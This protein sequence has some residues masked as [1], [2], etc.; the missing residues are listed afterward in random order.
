MSPQEGPKK[1]PHPVPSLPKVPKMSPKKLDPNSPQKGKKIT[2]AEL[3][4]SPPGW[5]KRRPPSVPKK[6]K[7]WENYS[8]P[9]HFSNSPPTKFWVVKEWVLKKKTSLEKKLGWEKF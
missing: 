9:T 6:R 8:T 2:P 1:F 5:E 4:Q 7:L 3:S